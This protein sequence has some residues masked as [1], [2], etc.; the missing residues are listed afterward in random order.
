MTTT[1]DCL[2]CRGTGLVT[3]D[4]ETQKCAKCNGS[5]EVPCPKCGGDGNITCVAC[6]GSKGEWVECVWCEGTGI[7]TQGTSQSNGKKC[8]SCDDG[9]V[10]TQ[11]TVCRGM[12][13]MICT[14]CHR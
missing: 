6:N 2:V 9:K 7:T 3:L 14:T 1:I 8:P 11:C 4:G 10:W 12:G 13:T 5:G